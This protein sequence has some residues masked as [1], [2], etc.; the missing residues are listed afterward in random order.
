MSRCDFNVIRAVAVTEH[1]NGSGTV[2]GPEC[3]CPY[4]GFFIE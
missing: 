1:F 2:I 3:V 4:D